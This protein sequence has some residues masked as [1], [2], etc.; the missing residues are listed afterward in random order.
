MKK[1]IKSV[2]K[3]AFSLMLIVTLLAG[4]SCNDSKK[5]DDDATV[6]EES[7]KDDSKNKVNANTAKPIV[8][9]KA[10]DY[11]L[12]IKTDTSV[13]DES[14]D[15]SDILYGIFFEDINHAIDGGIYA[16]MV[17]NRSFE[18]GDIA[19]DGAYTGWA[20]NDYAEFE[21]VDGS[22]D[23]TCLNENNTHYAIIENTGSEMSGIRNRGLLDGFAI[24]E[25]KEYRFTAFIKGLD[26][27]TGPVEIGMYE[28][29]EYSLGMGSAR[30]EKVSDEWWKYTAIMK[31]NVSGSDR[32]RLHVLIDEGK[33]AI[34]MVSFMPV[35]T[36]KNRENG[37]RADIVAYLEALEPKFIR[38]PGGCVVEGKT[39]ESQYSWKDSIGNGLEFV[40]NGQKTYGDVA[41]R[42]QGIDI[43][44]DIHGTSSNPYYMTYGV[45][46]Y[47]YF[48]LCEDLD[49]LAIPILNAGMLCPIQSPSYHYYS[50]DSEEFK[51]YVQDALDL[52]EFCRGDASTKWGAVR[53]GMG[54]AEPFELKY[55]GIG[56]EQWQD[57]Y[58]KHYKKFVEAFDEAAKQN[59]EMYGD[60]E[61]IVANGPVSSDR[62]GWDKVEENGGL[63]YAA[64]VDE[65]YYQTPE[66]FF[67]NT[68]RYDS[69]ER[70]TTKVF[71]G[72]YAAKSNT[73]KAALAEAAFMTA[74]ERNGD[75]VEMAC[76][77][78][79][80]GNTRTQWVPDM[81]WLDNNSV[82]GSINYYVQKMFSTNVGSTLLDTE[83]A[84]TSE[85]SNSLKGMVGVGT[86]STSATFDNIKIV[87]NKDDSVLYEQDFEENG[88]LKEGKIIAGSFS[89]KDGQLVQSY[90][91][92]TTNEKTGDVVY[93]GDTSFSDYTFTCTATKTGGNEGF[94]I[95]IAVQSAND[96]IFWNIGGWGNTVSCLQIVEGGSK[97]DQVSGTVSDISLKSDYEYE[98]KVV[99]SGNNIKCYLNKVL[100][101]DYTHEKS[102]NVYQ[103]T[104]TDE[105]GDIIIKL[106]NIASEEA[107][108]NVTI[109]DFDKYNSTA[110]AI[111]LKGEYLTEE[112]TY[113]D[114]EHI[115]PEEF[116]TE[117]SGEFTQKLPKYSITI[118]RIHKK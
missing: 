18:Y 101:I 80:F 98:I 21:V 22:E 115:V 39:Y 112:N 46:F 28:Q 36:Y 79:L 23:G 99:V 37:L 68:N 102:E 17:K 43:W 114:P 93:F 11:N 67:S 107:T 59:P 51:Q 47:E 118:L 26:G 3:Q 90:V 94:L 84:P 25:G 89:V 117:V 24:E 62:F 4:C 31:A 15:I 6:T 97:S 45:G 76:Y 75:V 92:N 35:D 83:F 41:A 95:P 104:S 1:R 38:F 33:I 66:W 78:P 113:E 63:D 56:N 30:I 7:K 91:G 55:I 96:N 42:P 40:I 57:E 54:H 87:S 81:I 10:L 116:Q 106:V 100:M 72:E 64:L 110:D 19:D 58:F 12:S 29:G 5:S 8:E 71:L 32:L 103:V 105:S 20:A 111:M 61:L 9:E 60:I 69:Y 16:E 70:N 50:T 27:Y 52:V 49:A 44:A 53:I 2:L 82:F 108:V 65:H 34:D 85:T 88:S 73:L 77:A 109:D 13:L 74:L 48:L 14:Y 86:W